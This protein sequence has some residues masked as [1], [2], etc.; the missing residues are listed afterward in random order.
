M[1]KKNLILI[2]LLIFGVGA[3]VYQIPYKKYLTEQ[4]LYTLLAKEAINK[5]EIHID[6]I[7]KDINSAR[8]GFTI[9]FNVKCSS[10]VYRYD[11]SFELDDWI[12][13]YSE[14]NGG[15]YIITEKIIFDEE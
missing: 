4:K 5:K 3:Y 12:K 1:K 8:G 13:T 15:P 7:I 9:Y 11:Y 6:Q 14:Q 2:V 10:L